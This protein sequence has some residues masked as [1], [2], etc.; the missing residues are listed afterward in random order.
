MVTS[1]WAIIALASLAPIDQGE[2]VPETAVVDGKPQGIFVGRSLLTGRAVCLLF[3]GGGRITRFIPAGGLEDFDW[4]RH[5]ANHAGDSG[6][7]EMTGGRLKITWGDGGV[8]RGPLTVRPTGIEFYGKRYSKPASA[9]ISDLAGRWESA[10]G[11]AAAGGEGINNLKD[12][13]VDQ[14]GRYRLGT[15][16][17]GD[18]AGRA[19]SGGTSRSGRLKIAGQTIT[20]TADDGTVTAHSFLPVPGEP[21]AAFSLDAN[22]FTRLN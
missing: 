8:H 15:T 6:S 19:V 3:L 11:T 9:T 13:T 2:R 18:A 21:L 20:L 5:R 17:G 7:W 12:L 1:R 10:R 4:A 16:T 14:D 22:L